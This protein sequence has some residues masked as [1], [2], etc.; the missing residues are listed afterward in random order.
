MDPHIEIVGAKTSTMDL[1]RAAAA[2]EPHV[3]LVSGHLAEGSLAGLTLLREL[4]AR[5]QR[6]NSIV[7]LDHPRREL[8]VDVF[9][10]GAKGVVFATERV[11]VFWRAIRSVHAGQVWANS[12]QLRYVLEALTVT[13][14]AP[15][16][17]PNG[18]SMLT[19]RQQELVDLVAA[20]LT[21]RDIARKLHLSEHTVKNYLARIFERLGV[22]SRI[23]L[24]MYTVYQRQAADPDDRLQENRVAA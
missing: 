24:A 23:E 12:Q 8:I 17:A 2:K 16:R 19:A 20:G 9:R 5:H 4:N 10:C 18:E 14:P 1:M 21:N 3:A 15:V 7:M 11:E 6:V 22:T 13:A